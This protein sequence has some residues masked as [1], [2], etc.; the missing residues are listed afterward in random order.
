MFP[1]VMRLSDRDINAI[2]S[3][4]NQ[5]H[6][7]NRFETASRVAYKVKEVLKID[8][9]MDTTDFLEKLLADYNYLATK[10]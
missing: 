1:E 10:E 7:T 4:V 2:K 3:V 9:L 5:L 8:T 6:K